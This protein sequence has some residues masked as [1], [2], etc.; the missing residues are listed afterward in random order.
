MAH[1]DQWTAARVAHAAKY[2]E[3]LAGSGLT[4]PART[5]DR[6]HVYHVYAV[7]TAHRG[8]LQAHLEQH[9]VG[10]GIHY[11]IPVHLQRC[12]A[13]LGH[14]RGDFPHAEQAA[15]EVLSLPM[16]PEMPVEHVEQVAALVNDWASHD[17]GGRCA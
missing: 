10:T 15:D 3:L 9:G 16:Y 8:G 6:T 14:H 13:E 7:R 17:V 11:P 2:D 4:L 12:F 5:E 1:L